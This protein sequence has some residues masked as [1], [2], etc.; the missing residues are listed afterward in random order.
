MSDETSDAPILEAD[1]LRITGETQAHAR[2]APA[3]SE[4]QAHGLDPTPTEGDAPASL[5]ITFPPDTGEG[6][7][8]IAYRPAT[9]PGDEP[10]VEIHG[11]S[12]WS[13]V[14]LKCAIRAV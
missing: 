1:G 8:T 12:R 4:T 3:P 5:R 14:R 9:D 13:D 2:K 6:T 7:L 11:F 10:E